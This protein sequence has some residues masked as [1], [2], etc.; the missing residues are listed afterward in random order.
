MKLSH[1]SIK[2]SHSYQSLSER[3]ETNNFEEDVPGVDL[4]QSLDIM[5]KVRKSYDDKNR[6]FWTSSDV[7]HYLA[8]MGRGRR[9]AV[10][11]LEID[12]TASYVHNSMHKLTFS[13]FRFLT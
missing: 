9:G 1:S 3:R 5:H 6:G 4:H 13:Q 10:V 8:A 12:Q 7:E 2:P 11:S